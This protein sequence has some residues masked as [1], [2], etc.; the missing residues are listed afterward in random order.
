M[1]LPPAWV[2][3]AWLAVR[4]GNDEPMVQQMQMQSFK[5][6]AFAGALLCRERPMPGRSERPLARYALRGS[7]DRRPH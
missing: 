6:L 7:Q 1:C 5:T 2:G 4:F 3:G